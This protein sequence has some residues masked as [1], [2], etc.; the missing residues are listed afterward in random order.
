MD[1]NKKNSSIVQEIKIVTD[2]IEKLK[3]GKCNPQQIILFF[4][5]LAKTCEMFLFILYL[6]PVHNLRA[7]I[8]MGKLKHLLIQ[9]SVVNLSGLL[10]HI[11]LL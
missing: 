5:S 1:I 9:Y 8:F 4:A 7:S 3:G 6:K 2:F 10:I 11:L